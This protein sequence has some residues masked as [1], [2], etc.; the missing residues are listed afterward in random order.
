MI[1]EKLSGTLAIGQA[2][3]PADA[4][5]GIYVHWPFCLSKCPYCD[6]NS[7]VRHQKV[8]QSKYTA[9]LVRELEHQAQLAKG[10][11]VGSIFFGG[12]TPSLMEPRVIETVLEAIASLWPVSKDVEISMEANP[13]SVEAKNF[14]AYRAAGVN[15]L[16]LG[17]QALRDED[18]KKLGR[19]HTVEEALDALTLAQEH[20]D[21][22]SF[23][24]IYA[25]EGQTLK[26]WRNELRQA[27]KLAPEH[28]SLYQLTIEPDTRFEQLYMKGVLEIPDPDLA[29]AFYDVTMELTARAGL[30][31]YEISNHAR[32]GADCRHN[33]IYWRYG[34]Y[35]G[36]GPGAHARLSVQGKRLAL[37]TEK[38]PETWLARVEAEGHAGTDMEW[39]ESEEQGDE[40]L[41]MGLRLREGIDPRRYAL[42][43]GRPLN[44]H[45]VNMLEEQ[46]FLERLGNGRI[47]A[48]HE[49]WM[50]LDALV[51]DLAV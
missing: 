2:P 17:I 19:L 1:N 20:F 44:P 3:E 24:L 31:A 40:M 23:D 10:K 35:A 37:V 27:L 33:L 15:R 47:R 28:L 43:T 12:G 48:T 30:P 21:R 9:A 11:K 34:D 38:H 36:V 26:D 16:S 45:R 18:L 4:G 6:F 49:G 39:L 46:N 7:H 42:I 8:D 5:F 13:T 14:A 50:L 29:R 51:A 32:P 25:R 22:V 41:L